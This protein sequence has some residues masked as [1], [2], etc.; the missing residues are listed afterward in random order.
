MP[1]A[2]MIQATQHMKLTMTWPNNRSTDNIVVLELTRDM[3]SAAST[4]QLACRPAICKS[5]ETLFMG[6]AKTHL[7]VQLRPRVLEFHLCL[8][9]EVPFHHINELAIVLTSN[10]WIFDH[11][12]TGRA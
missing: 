5:H 11:H 7:I 12:A 10:A 1:F 9:T 2:E 6:R 4:L 3:S 8:L